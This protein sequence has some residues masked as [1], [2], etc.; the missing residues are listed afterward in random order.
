MPFFNLLGLWFVIFP[1]LFIQDENWLLI[2]AVIGVLIMLLGLILR[3]K[4]VKKVMNKENE[5]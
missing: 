2:L 5:S 4:L 3:Y 1:K